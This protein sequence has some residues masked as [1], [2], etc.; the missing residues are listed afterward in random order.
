M[1]KR[2]HLVP[3]AVGLLFVGGSSGQYPIFDRIAD[4]VIL[5]YQ[6]C[7]CEQLLERKDEPKS[8]RE[9]EV[10]QALRNDLER[11][12]AFIH[13]VEGPIANKLFECGMIP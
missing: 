10:I 2:T 11:R 9:L 13:K 3:L 1:I 8:S 4:K 6:Q 7:S 5:K 12:A